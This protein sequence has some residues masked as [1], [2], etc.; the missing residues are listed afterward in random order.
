MSH[1]LHLSGLKK[2]FLDFHGGS[3]NGSLP[4]VQGMQI[5]SPIKED[6][7]CYEAAESV[8]YSY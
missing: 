4:A 6:S 5:P 3:V 7:T 8:H 1:N 2:H